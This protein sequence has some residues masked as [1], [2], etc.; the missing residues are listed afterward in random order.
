MTCEATDLGGC[1]RPDC[2][3]SG[4]CQDH[5]DEMLAWLLPFAIT[6]LSVSVISAC[7]YFGWLR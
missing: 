7:A 2:E 5:A 1:N 3:D 4:Q 6:V